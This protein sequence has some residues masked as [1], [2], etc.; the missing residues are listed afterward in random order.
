M[1]RDLVAITRSPEKANLASNHLA[2]NDLWTN[3]VATLLP[4]S[5]GTY[6]L[7]V[8]GSSSA[9]VK[10]VRD[11]IG[12]VDGNDPDQ[13]WEILSTPAAPNEVDQK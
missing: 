9:V 4:L 3:Q 10:S 8:S 12:L 1:P 11:H 6:R 7:T 2:Q 5:N 13:P